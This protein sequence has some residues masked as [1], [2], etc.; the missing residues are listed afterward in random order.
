MRLCRTTM[1]IPHGTEIIDLAD[2]SFCCFVIRARIRGDI[3]RPQ[4]KHSNAQACKGRRQVFRFTRLQLRRDFCSLSKFF[5]IIFRRHGRYF[6]SFFGVFITSFNY[7]NRSKECERPSRIR[8]NRIYT[9]TARGVSRID[10]SF[11]L[12][13]SGD[14]SSFLFRIFLCLVEFGGI[15]H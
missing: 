6:F 3:R 2:R 9:L 4:R 15:F 11:D 12:S 14:V 10:F 8:L 5:R 1:E 7:C 13:I